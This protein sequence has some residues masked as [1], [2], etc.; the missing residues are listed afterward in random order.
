MAS[1]VV[2]MLSQC[3]ELLMFDE[4]EGITQL[5]GVVDINEVKFPQY[6]IPWIE[7]TSCLTRSILILDL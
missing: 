7:I 1:L 6:T 5:S 3:H 4:V 2:M